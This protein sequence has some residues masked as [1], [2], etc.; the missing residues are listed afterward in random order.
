MLQNIFDKLW[1]L[2]L[3]SN[4]EEI[5]AFV[6]EPACRWIFWERLDRVSQCS[7]RLACRDFA[8]RSTTLFT[9]A[10]VRSA[11]QLSDVVEW[12]S[13]E[14]LLICPGTSDIA[15]MTKYLQSLE[16]DYYTAPLVHLKNLTLQGQALTLWELPFSIPNLLERLHQLNSLELAYVILQELNPVAPSKT[17]C[18]SLTRLTFKHVTCGPDI[19]Q[20]LANLRTLTHLEL[21][22]CSLHLEDTSI[23]LAS[24]LSS[25]NR[26]TAL[27]LQHISC[28]SHSSST[29]SPAG[30]GL[31]PQPYDLCMSKTFLRAVLPNFIYLSVLEL[32]S[33]HDFSNEDAAALSNATTSLCS[34]TI[35]SLNLNPDWRPV[36]GKPLHVG[37]PNLKHLCLESGAAAKGVPVQQLWFLLGSTPQLES[38]SPSPFPLQTRCS[39]LDQAAV[40]SNLLDLL[41][42]PL[43]ACSQALSIIGMMGFSTYDAHYM[44]RTLAP[45]VR[46][47]TSFHLTEVSIDCEATMA[48][49]LA[50]PHMQ[51]LRLHSCDI[52]GGALDSLHVLAK[53]ST[54]TLS[55][56]QGTALG[57]AA[58]LEF[59]GQGVERPLRLEVNRETLKSMRADASSMARVLKQ[60]CV[61]VEFEVVQNH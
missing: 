61:N 59:F 25:L 14:D 38:I 29:T 30:Q 26:L 41:Q 34:L 55:S 5:S 39:E 40:I 20:A 18:S 60:K 28:R 47:V 51:D 44:F 13:L 4:V 24:A 42:G 12:C 53:L 9:R 48:M 33:Y 17:S 58:S 6:F 3:I 19:F 49:V 8:Q 27:S 22:S 35:G 37:L 50:M 57:Y 21:T 43:Y 1:M 23:D 15:D 56:C 31:Q 10:H 11:A 2:N 7:V 36:K 32:P 16:V 52:K 54:L 46:H 45:S